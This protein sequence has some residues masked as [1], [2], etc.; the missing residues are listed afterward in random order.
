MK[1]IFFLCCLTSTAAA[2]THDTDF[3]KQMA[4]INRCYIAAIKSGKT[5]PDPWTDTD[6]WSC[7]QNQGFIFC[8]DCQI[9]SVEGGGPCKEDKANGPDRPTCW[10]EKK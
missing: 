9:F 5:H 8:N 1:W 3:P 7:M 6:F 2:R 4:A 10:R